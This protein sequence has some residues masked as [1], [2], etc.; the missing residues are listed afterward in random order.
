MLSRNSFSR[1]HTRLMPRLGLQATSLPDLVNFNLICQSAVSRK[2]ICMCACVYMCIGEREEEGKKRKEWRP[3]SFLI[4]LETEAAINHYYL[5]KLKLAVREC[6]SP[7][8]HTYKAFS[9]RTRIV[10]N[11][12]DSILFIRCRMHCM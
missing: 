6:V 9:T 10:C 11:T 1:T 7:L 3:H 8:S 12:T 5:E 4:K 2:A